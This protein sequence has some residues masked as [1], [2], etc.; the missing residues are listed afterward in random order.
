MKRTLYAAV[1]LTLTP[2]VYAG[3]LSFNFGED[4]V[5]AQFQAPVGQEIGTELA[6]WHHEDDHDL[7]TLGLFALGE[8]GALKGSVGVKGY[9]ADFDRFDGGGAAFGGNVKLPL[10]D[11]LALHGRVFIGPSSTSFDDSDGYKEWGLSFELNLFGNSSLSFG[12]RDIEVDLEQG[13]DFEFQDDF[14]VGLNLLF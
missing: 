11:I 2:A 1:L 14:Y 8:R 5:G 12:Y 10:S 3:A 4:S 6:W 9:Y 7:G 13:G